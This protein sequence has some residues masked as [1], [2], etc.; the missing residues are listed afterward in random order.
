MIKH[1][2][3]A[4]AVLACLSGGAKAQVNP[5]VGEIRTF[6]FTFC[7]YG[8]LA[9]KGQLLSITSYSTLY[10]LLGTR[11][12]GDGVST[13][14]LPRTRVLYTFYNQPLTQCIAYL[15]VFPSQG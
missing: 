8:W 5:Y 13:F 12:G 11:Y 4:G 14:A 10:Q 6:A 1:I 2:L 7:P 9:T 3:L 15:G